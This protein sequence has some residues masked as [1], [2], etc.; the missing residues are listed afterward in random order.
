MVLFHICTCILISGSEIS[1]T[2]FDFEFQKIW[3]K[4][5]EHISYQKG[6]LSTIVNIFISS[7][8]FG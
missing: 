5:Y 4:I 2:L 6:D 7:I 8:A 3:I 1:Y